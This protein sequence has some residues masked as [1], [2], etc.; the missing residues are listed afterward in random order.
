MNP[1]LWYFVLSSLLVSTVGC[2]PTPMD[3]MYTAKEQFLLAL[4]FD[5]CGISINTQGVGG[6]KFIKSEGTN[7]TA[8]N[9]V[10]DISISKREELFQIIESS[11]FQKVGVGSLSTNVHDLVVNSADS[12]VW[13]IHCDFDEKQNQLRCTIG[14]KSEGNTIYSISNHQ[15]VRV[16]IESIIQKLPE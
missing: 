12:G 15:Q 11:D 8:N 7:Y 2:L 9:K 1:R 5:D 13:T 14:F 4:S 6:P 3:E 16:W 10:V